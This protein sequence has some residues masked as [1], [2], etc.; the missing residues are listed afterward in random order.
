MTARIEVVKV[1]RKHRVEC[2]GLGEVTCRSCRDLGWM[3]WS[4]FYEHIADALKAANLLTPEL[5]T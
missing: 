1:L 5:A 2:T 4:A 3:S